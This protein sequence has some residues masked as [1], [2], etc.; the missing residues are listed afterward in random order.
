MI[1]KEDILLLQKILDFLEMTIVID[2]ALRVVSTKTNRII[3]FYNS[4][5]HYKIM[6]NDLDAVLENLF[7]AQVFVPTIIKFPLAALSVDPSECAVVK[8]PFY[9]LTKEE[10]AIKV[11]LESWT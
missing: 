3:R 5:I 10:A 4:D 8:N 1:S 2:K 11:D 9:R 7:K 6:F